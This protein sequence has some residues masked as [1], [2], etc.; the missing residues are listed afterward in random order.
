M[1]LDTNALNPF[2]TEH[3]LYVVY[4]MLLSGFSLEEIEVYKTVKSSHIKE[5]IE[6]V[7]HK[8]VSIIIHISLALVKWGLMH[9]L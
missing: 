8:V 9:V 7:L 5:E 4:V 3:V 1:T 6:A 2:F